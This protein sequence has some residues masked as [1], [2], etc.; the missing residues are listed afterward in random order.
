LK[1]G[2]VESMYFRLKNVEYN[3]ESCSVQFG[4]V[5]DNQT[6]K[7]Y[8]EIDAKTDSDIIDH[9]LQEVKLYH[10]NGFEIG[11]KTLRNLKG[12]IFEWEKSVNQLG[13]EAG[14][15]YVL[16][17]ENV[18]RGI[19]EILDLTK[20]KIWIKWTGFANVYWDNEFAD[21]VPFETVIETEVP[22]IPKYKVVNGMETTCIKLNKYTEL[23]L[24]NFDDILTECNRCREMWQ[25]DD[26][27]A[28][29]KYNAILKL[30][31]IYR[32]LEYFGQAVYS[33]SATKC[34]VSFDN[35]CPI[36]VQITKTAIDTY[37]KKYN[38]YIVCEQC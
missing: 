36:K 38:F 26:K 5:P 10:N 22:E 34:D 2:E 31:L 18:T 7:M 11:G 28:W 8:I 20:D 6:L 14:S 19:I 12:K 3:V 13:E 15:L 27:D 16:E 9:E 37:N 23:V 24:L 29:N 4:I 30:K 21:N 32:G 1:K 25:N 17:H 35:A 33:G